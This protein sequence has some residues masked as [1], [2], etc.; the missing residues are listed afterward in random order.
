MNE[1]HFRKKTNCDIAVS[2]IFGGFYELKWLNWFSFNINLNDK[3]NKFEVHL[4]QNL[5]KLANYLTRMG[6]DATCVQTLNGHNS[7]ICRPIL[8]FD[9]TNMISSS[10]QIEWSEY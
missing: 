1:G 7:L 9:H 3:Q 8:T 6:Q 4:L 10:I 5:A 2:N